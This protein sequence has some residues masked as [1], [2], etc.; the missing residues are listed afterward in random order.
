M[1]FIKNRDRISSAG[2][3][4]VIIVDDFISTEMLKDIALKTQRKYDM[5]NNTKALHEAGHERRKKSFE[6]KRIARNIVGEENARK[7]EMFYQNTILL[8]AGYKPLKI[9]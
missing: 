8:L 3:G 5:P 6:S 9:V 2:I 7:M 1:P 4:Q